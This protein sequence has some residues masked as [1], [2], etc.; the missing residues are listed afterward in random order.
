M[1]DAIQEKGKENFLFLIEA[2][3]KSKA[4][5]HYAEVETQLNEDVLRSRLP[6]GERRYYNK[7]IA[8]MKFV[9]PDE[10]P[11]ETKMKIRSTLK[12]FWQNTEHHY[13]NKM[14]EDEKAEWNKKYRIGENNSTKRG[15]TEE[16]LKNWIDQTYKGE[17]NAMF[18][19]NGP[20]HPRW[21]VKLSDEQKSRQSEKMKGRFAGEN[22]PRYGKSPFEN[23]TPEEMEDRRKTLSER[24]AGDKNP[25]YG[26]PCY[27]AMNPD[28]I[29]EWKRKISASTKG[30]PKSEEAK[31]NMRKPRGPCQTLQCPKYGKVGRGGNMK[32]YHFDNCKQP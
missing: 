10:L 8:N 17:N 6:N 2:L 22:N 5:L 20:L 21:G 7:M 18:G 31:A 23:F 9:T 3:Y 28:E 25:M 15:K 16:E 26:K 12:L 1:N 32:R 13:F 30:K 24:M 14:S 19:Q 27:H 11:E 4:A 29:N